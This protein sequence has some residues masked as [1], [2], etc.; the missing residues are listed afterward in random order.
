MTSNKKTGVYENF[1]VNFENASTNI[2]F[3]HSFDKIIKV[4]SNEIEINFPVKRDNGKIE[5]FKGYRVQHNNMMGPYYGGVR[6]HPSVSL[7]EIRTLA[8]WMT[9][10]TALLNIPLSG[11]AGGVKFNPQEYSDDEIER[12][13]RRFIYNLGTN[14]GSDYDIIGP[15]INTNSQIMAWMLDTLLFSVKPQMRN[16]QRHGVTGKPVE[17][18]GTL[19]REE[20]IGMGLKFMIERWAEVNA[21]D[22]EN[23]KVSIQGFSNT[24]FWISKMLTKMGA[25]IIA[26]ESFTGAISNEK[27]I[28][29]YALM[30]HIRERKSMKDFAGGQFCDHKSFM[31]KETDI[32][33][34]AA[35]ENQINKTTANIIKAKLIIEGANGATTPEADKILTD[36]GIDLIPCLISNSGGVIISYFEWLQNK[37][38]EYWSYDK[39]IEKLKIKITSAYIKLEENSKLNKCSLRTS[40]FIVALNRLQ[41]IYEERGIF[42]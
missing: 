34:P 5:I 24:G 1:K 2:K 42:P 10:K 40:A 25:R 37:R 28:D 35:L 4:P 33:I 19:G 30:N 12:I 26:I 36:K 14:I 15:D 27:G 41:K 32:F 6:F 39:V 23:C 20:A 16:S 8:M 9:L 3:N 11:S 18:G 31:S 29:V 7:D 17:L 13:S 22:I 38:S 21:F